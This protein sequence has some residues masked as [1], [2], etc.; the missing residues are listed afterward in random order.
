VAIIAAAGAGRRAGLRT[1]KQ[2]LRV[3]GRTLLEH[4][5][6]RIGAHP[7]VDAIVV[8][9]PRGRTRA[10]AA[11]LRRHP[12]VAAVVAGGRRRQDSVRAGLRAPAAREAGLVLVHD[13]ARPMVPGRV[14]ADVL[15]MARRV[16]AAVPGLAPSDTVKLVAASGRVVR[17]L[18][19]RRLRLVQTPQAFRADWLREAFEKDRRR[20]GE[21]TDDASLL[22]AI[23]RPVAVVEGDPANFKVTSPGDVRRVRALARRR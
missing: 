15:R 10:V 20:G 6:A 17:T 2:L 13:A 7:E 9:A 5:V 11:L 23:G 21:A 22:E 14:V 4:A 1:P 3:G 12:K 8:A 18:P 16:G 19:R